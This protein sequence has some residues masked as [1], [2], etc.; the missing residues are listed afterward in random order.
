MSKGVIL[1]IAGEEAIVLTADGEF[2]KIHVVGPRKYQIG[3]EISV[4]AVQVV[5]TRKK[6]GRSAILSVSIAASLLIIFF[7]M[8]MWLPLK[9]EGQAVAY[10]HLDINPSIEISLDQSLKVI[11]LRGLNT[12]GTQL[13]NEM[14]QYMQ[15]DLDQVAFMLIVKANQL[16]YIQRNHEILLATTFL[17]Q[18]YEQEYDQQMTNV[19]HQLEQRVLEIEPASNQGKPQGPGVPQ[20]LDYVASPEDEEDLDQLIHDGEASLAIHW[21]SVTN[22]VREQAL[23][24]AVSAGK[25]Q[26]YL[27]ALDQGMDIDLKQI[28]ESSISKLARDLSGIYNGSGESL[29]DKNETQDALEN[30]EEDSTSLQEEEYNQLDQ[31]ATVADGTQQT[32]EEKGV[33][34]LSKEQKK[35]DTQQETTAQKQNQK[36]NQ[37]QQTKQSQDQQ[38]ETNQPIEQNE[39]PQQP[40]KAHDEKNTSKHVEQNKE[41][42][43]KLGK[44]KEALILE[45]EK[46]W[47]EKWKEKAAQLKQPNQHKD[48]NSRNEHQDKKEKDRE[49]EK[50]AKEKEAK[51]KEAKHQDKHKDNDGKHR[52]WKEQHSDKDK[53]KQKEKQ[54]NHSH[55]KNKERD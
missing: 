15:E 2:K 22:E 28:K 1:E 53:E 39:Q 23:E 17:D 43:Y 35:Q 55:E 45:L 32:D 48:S 25:Y 11:G 42:K 10:A 41:Q 37:K 16:G 52:N 49:K 6:R 21:L 27:T 13:I 54:K 9:Q 38:K 14:D 36:Q 40:S 51:E 5:P 7:A 44:D 12:E 18:S 34:K 33:D 29:F 4:P 30:L 47:H 3:D 20:G 26:V 31:G 24:N 50:Q 19:F 46:I 8:Y